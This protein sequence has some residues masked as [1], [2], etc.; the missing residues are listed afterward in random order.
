MSS[1]QASFHNKALFYVCLF[2]AKASTPGAKLK[3][4]RTKRMENAMLYLILQLKVMGF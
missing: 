3:I 1:N 4:R 2:Y